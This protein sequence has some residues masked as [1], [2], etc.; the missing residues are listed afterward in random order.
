LNP[1]IIGWANYFN[2]GNSARFRD[3]VRQALWKLCW[4]WSKRKHKKWGKKKIAKYYF[5]REDGSKFKG[6]IWTFFGETK[7]Q[8]RYK[9]INKIE[10][11]KKIYLQDILNTN[12]ILASKEYIIPKKLESIHA[13][14]EEYGKLIDFQA[15]L[16]IKS[17]SQYN[18]RKGKL[19]KKQNS[20]C[21]ICNQIISLDQIANGT[22]HIHHIAPI[23]KGG[24]RSK[25]ENMQ[26]VHSWCHREIN[27]FK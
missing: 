17:L 7:S 5:L 23:F 1:I 4:S 19:L 6:R 27:H 24:S 9:E 8:S 25:I 21:S 3:Y 18:P 13:F 16:N 10:K 22:I 26:L 15:T 12:A 2:M 11:K 20:M 14:H